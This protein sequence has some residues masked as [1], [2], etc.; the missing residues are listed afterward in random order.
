MG[1]YEDYNIILINLDGFR[2]DKIDH[3]L[4]LKNLKKNSYYFSKMNTVAPYTFASLHSVFSGMYPSSHG[5]NGYYNIFEFKKNEI[6][7]LP[8]MLKKS[9]YYTAC[10]I[11]SEIVI[12]KQGFDEWNIFEEKSVDFISRHSELIK[13]LSKKDKFFLFLHYTEVHKHLVREI[14]EKENQGKNDDFFKSKEK[15]HKRLDSYLSSCDD[16][17]KAIISSLK[18]SNIYEKTILIFFADHGTSIG[19]KFGEKF[20][21]VFTYDYTINVFSI[22]HIPNCKPKIIEKQCRTIDIF[23]TIAEIIKQHPSIDLK[24]I[25][26][27]SLFPLIEKINTKDREVFVETGGLYGPWPSP[28]KH[29]VFCVKFNDH[30]LIYND[31]PQTWEF[32]NLKKDPNENNNIYEQNLTEIIKYKKRL[33]FYLNMNKINTNIS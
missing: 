8:E 18:E 16:Y 25:Q 29:N 27:E 33:L 5:V 10:D 22:I 28:D 20:Y 30:K 11:I 2:R 23:P 12:P 13:K 24:N 32:Y 14:I 26:G 3:C 9:K 1:L 7:S 17:V 15:N 6:V 21:G 19:E 4:T 31:T